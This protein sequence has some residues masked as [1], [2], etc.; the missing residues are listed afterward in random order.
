MDNNSKGIFLLRQFSASNCEFDT[1]VWVTEW[2]VMEGDLKIH[3]LFLD[4]EY[5]GQKVSLE[6]F[7]LDYLPAN[8]T[9]NTYSGERVAHPLPILSCQPMG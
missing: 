4:T 7:H 8:Q 3:C 2:H 9:S 1:E 6:V 5:W